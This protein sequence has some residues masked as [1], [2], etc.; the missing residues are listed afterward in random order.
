MKCYAINCLLGYQL[1]IT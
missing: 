1:A